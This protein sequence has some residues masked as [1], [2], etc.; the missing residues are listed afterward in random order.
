MI[1]STI[2]QLQAVLAAKLTIDP[3]FSGA[4]STN[5]K[6]VPI[7]TE[8]IGDVINYTQ[9]AIGL[10]GL[11]VIILTPE[12]KLLDY[13][14][15]PLVGMVLIQIQVSE[16]YAINQSKTGIGIPAQTLSTRVVELLHWQPNGVVSGID[17]REELIKF[18]GIKLV[19]SRNDQPQ[20]VTYLLMFQTMLAIKTI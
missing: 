9:S 16:F 1:T 19:K 5:G 17:P 3:V 4:Q 14:K 10:M 13:K 12:F 15:S 20:A 6:P 2:A 8:K 7:V 11:V 18:L